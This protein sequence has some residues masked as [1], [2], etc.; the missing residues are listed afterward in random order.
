VSQS[1]RA[2]EVSPRDGLDG[3]RDLLN[4]DHELN[5][6]LIEIS[7][8]T[9]ELAS[10]R[11]KAVQEDEATHKIQAPRRIESKEQIDEL[12]RRLEGLK[13]KL[14]VNVTW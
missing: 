4:H 6:R 2:I 7:T 5:T 3:L 1:A 14:P 12:V 13:D 11:E 10:K 8:H 9:Q